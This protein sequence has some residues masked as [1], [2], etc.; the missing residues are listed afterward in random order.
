MVYKQERFLLMVTAPLVVLAAYFLRE[1][2]RRKQDCGRAGTHGDVRHLA[3]R[4]SRAPATTIAP[5]W[6]TSE[7]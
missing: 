4:R 2:G 5:A 6:P 1:V 3:D 7:E